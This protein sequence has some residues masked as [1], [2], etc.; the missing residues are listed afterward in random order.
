MILRRSFTFDAAHSIRR[1]GRCENLHGHT[2][3]L[4]VSLNGEPDANGIVMDFRELRD[5]V[6]EHVLS[7]LDHRYLNDVVENPTAENLVRWIADRLEPVLRGETHR[8]LE[9]E[10]FESSETSVSLRIDHEGRPEG[11]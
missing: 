6:Q 7:E 8:L 2:Y 9:V 4:T 3:R 10:L 11:A 5:R 1:M